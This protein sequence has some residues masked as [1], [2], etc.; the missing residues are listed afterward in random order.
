[1]YA[2]T[3][4]HCSKEMSGRRRHYCDSACRNR[5]YRRRLAGLEETSY[6]TT[7]GASRGR[8]RMTELTRA[9]LELRWTMLARFA[10]P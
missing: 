9:E 6:S 5:G 3:C 4:R 1:M 8:V 10:R 2:L 7:T